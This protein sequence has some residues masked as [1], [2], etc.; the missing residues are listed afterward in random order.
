MEVNLAVFIMAVG[1]LAMV[2][3]YPLGF[4][5]SQ[6][7]LDDV[8]GA[9]LADAV[10]NPLV[11][12]L[13]ST[14]MS[15]QTWNNICGGQGKTVPSSGWKAFCTDS[16]SYIPGNNL[17]GKDVISKIQS[18][19]SGQGSFDIPESGSSA[20]NGLYYALVA[21]QTEANTIQLSFRASRRKGQ[22]FVQPFYFTEVHFQ[23][24]KEQ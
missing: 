21:K 15:W 1:V 16:D 2:G 4:R 13:S 19:Y 23:G 17:N 6:Q 22:L 9:I 24:F 11:A 5:E 10:L 14:N 7:S 8:A 20:A 12:A 18:A 3:L